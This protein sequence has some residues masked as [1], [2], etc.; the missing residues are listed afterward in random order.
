MPGA[1]GQAES[2]A[3]PNSGVVH[4]RVPQASPRWLLLHKL[5]TR[6]KDLA[7]LLMWL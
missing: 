7:L 3:I 2:R 4:V 6:C 1:R 5:P